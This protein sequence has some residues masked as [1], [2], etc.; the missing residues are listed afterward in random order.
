MHYTEMIL[1]LVVEVEQ[2]AK[3]VQHL[4]DEVAKLKDENILLAAQV[5]NLG[6][7]NT[8]L[9]KI[10]SCSL[11]GIRLDSVTGYCC[12]RTNCPT[13]LGPITCKLTT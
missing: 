12:S 5:R 1:R 13:G 2:L 9:Q 7:W 4:T 6:V 3:S 8:P 10:N 11:C